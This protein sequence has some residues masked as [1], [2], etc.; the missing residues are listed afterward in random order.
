[1]NNVEMSVWLTGARW[2]QNCKNKKLKLNLWNIFL[3]SWDCDDSETV[4]RLF[5]IRGGGKQTNSPERTKTQE[6]GREGHL[7]ADIN[8]SCPKTSLKQRLWILTARRAQ[9]KS[10]TYLYACCWVSY[11]ATNY[12]RVI[13][14]LND[15]MGE[16]SRIKKCCCCISLTAGTRGVGALLFTLTLGRIADSPRGCSLI[17]LY[18]FVSGL[19]GQN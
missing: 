14:N 4:F 5:V 17:T 16:W 9:W 18:R 3:L 6:A 10:S 8:N 2:K 11:L 1:M 7:P 15:T 13:G 12:W 19:P